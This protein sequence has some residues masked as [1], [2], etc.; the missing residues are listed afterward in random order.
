M[1]DADADAWVSESISGAIC[2]GSTPVCISSVAPPLGGGTPADVNFV[3]TNEPTTQISK[4]IA[5]LSELEQRVCSIARDH[6]ESSFD[7]SRSSG[8]VA[9]KSNK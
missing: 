2:S 9:W 4:Y 6:L 7:L 5:S 1:A 3:E 8:F